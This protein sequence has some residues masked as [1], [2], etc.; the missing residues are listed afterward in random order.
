MYG[1]MD[2]IYTNM[3]LKKIGK[4]LPLIIS[5]SSFAGAGHFS[6]RW[7]GDNHANFE[8]LRISL[9]GLMLFQFFGIPMV[10]ADICGKKKLS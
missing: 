7:T 6:H 1:L 3:A 2:S 4:H 10:G 9:P 8:F 5:R